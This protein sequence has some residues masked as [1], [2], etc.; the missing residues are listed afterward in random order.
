MTIDKPARLLARESVSIR[1]E[2]DILTARRQVREA[3]VQLEFGNLGM[4]RAVTAASELARNTLIHGGGGT[5]QMNTW[6]T[7][8]RRGIELVFEDQGKGIEDI[9]RAMTDGF[10]TGNGMGL[11]LSGSKRL[12]DEFEIASSPGQGTRVRVVI[13]S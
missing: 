1:E 9:E 4:T 5:M 2:A 12:M 7:P 3:A 8:T 13:W 10:T 11:G 6:A